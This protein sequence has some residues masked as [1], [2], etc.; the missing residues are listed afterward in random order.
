MDQ[1]SIKRPVKIAYNK[2]V[3]NLAKQ[4]DTTPLVLC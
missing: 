2:F 4:K 3:I 1:T